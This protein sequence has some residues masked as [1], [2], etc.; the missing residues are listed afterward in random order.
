MR[1][2]I[3]QLEAE[4]A[5][6]PKDVKLLTEIAAIY[7]FKLED[8]AKAKYYYERVLAIN[9]EHVLALDALDVLNDKK[10]HPNL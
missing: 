8:Y 6:N 10:L 9:P 1:H 3:T 7:E 5:T 2:S 4:L